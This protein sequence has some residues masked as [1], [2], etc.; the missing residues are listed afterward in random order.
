MINLKSYIF[1]G[2]S[3]S[4]KGTQATLLMESL[5]NASDKKII[6]LE[7]GKRFR[8]FIEGNSL[9]NKLSK[10]LMDDFKSQPAFLAIRTWADALVEEFS[11]EEDLVFDGTPRSLIEAEA[12]DTAL[13]F[14]QFNNCYVINLAVSRERSEQ[15]LKSRGRIDDTTKG[16]KNRL[17]WFE[18]D[19]L[20]VIDYYR[21]NQDYKFME[22]N[23]EQSIAKVH[24]DILQSL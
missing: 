8:K 24:S 6:Y 13:K 1:I 18:T 14:F 10:Q 3:G 7:T 21:Q 12:L 5:T 17:D 20:P 16:I 19:V 4:G 15:H 9:A 2:Q 22:I 11:G 23:G